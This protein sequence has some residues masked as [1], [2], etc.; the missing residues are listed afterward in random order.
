[1]FAN[2]FGDFVKGRDLSAYPTSIQNGILLHRRIDD[3]IDHHPAV[4][5]LLHDLYEHLPKVSSIAVDLFFDHLLAKRWETYHQLP[6]RTFIQNFYRAEIQHQSYFSSEF[7]Y[8]ISKMR[9][10]DWLFQYQYEY[11]LQKACSGVSSRISFPNA[12]DTAPEVF[13][14]FESRIADAF[15]IFMQDAAPYHQEFLDSLK[16]NM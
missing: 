6:L 1:M 7:L 11:G 15:T 2:L 3:Y 8:M 4:I 10:R 13:K 9:E 12:L 16:G 5:E 14:Q